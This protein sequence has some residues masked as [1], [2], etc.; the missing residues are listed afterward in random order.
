MVNSGFSPWDLHLELFG[1]T[2][3]TTITFVMDSVRD[4]SL[5][6]LNS[7]L[8]CQTFGL[9]HI[10]ALF[11]HV[12]AVLSIQDDTCGM[13]TCRVWSDRFHLDPLPGTCV[14][15]RWSCNKR[16]F[17]RYQHPVMLFCSVWSD[18]F[19]LDPCCTTHCEIWSW[20]TSTE[21]AIYIVVYH[22]TLARSI[23]LI[24]ATWH[25][26]MAWGATGYCYGSLLSDI[27]GR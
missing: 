15:I 14:C 22:M 12:T 21:S 3:H 1:P 6:P 18:I 5:K 13:S 11:S 20:S 9:K 27:R 23:K 16:L 10:L 4:P 26:M 2:C 25:M 19:C 8:S 17:H 7:G 24:V